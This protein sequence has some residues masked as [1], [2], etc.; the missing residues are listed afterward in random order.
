MVNT[1]IDYI[2]F[3]KFVGLLLVILAHVKPPTPIL[4]IRCFDV[5]FLVILSGFLANRSLER[6]SISKGIINTQYFIKRFKRLVLPTWIMLVLVFSCQ[7]AVG[8][9]HPIK[10]YL[11]SFCLTTKY[12]I[13][14]V[15]IIL[16]FLYC[17]FAAPILKKSLSFQ[18][19]WL[20]M[21]LVYCLY[22]I[23][24]HFR[25][26]TENIFILNT[27]YYIIPYGFLTALGMKYQTMT[28]RTKL[29]VFIICFFIFV[30]CSVYYHQ[31][32]GGFQHP[33]IAKYPPRIFFLS[34]SIA[35]SFLLLMLCEGRDNRLFR[36]RP[37]HF[38]SSHSLWI[39]LWHIFFLMLYN[40]MA[41]FDN[42]IVRYV[43]VLILSV[44]TVWLQ[45][46]LFDKLETVFNWSIPKYMRG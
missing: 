23:A 33:S 20:V 30:I 4:F 44:T 14:Y 8:T 1:R 45:N 29:M 16:I 39:Y 34:Y 36:F 37:V 42:W 22:E 46:L 9:V 32:Q 43:F 18:P 7:A 6:M 40:K 38:I 15:W 35:V 19:F 11:F 21:A 26:G 3:L 24:Y 31:T 2:D 10:Y 28:K 12:G 41:P 5:P 17:A 13:G 25:W 27:V